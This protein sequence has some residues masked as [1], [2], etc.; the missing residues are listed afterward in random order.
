MRLSAPREGRHRCCCGQDGQARELQLGTCIRSCSCGMS[1]TQ[2]IGCR[3][4]PRWALHVIIQHAP[5]VWHA[6]RV[7]RLLHGILQSAASSNAGSVSVPC[8]KIY[9][10][11]RVRL[12]CSVFVLCRGTCICNVPARLF[13]TSGSIPM[14]GS[15]PDILP[16]QSTNIQANPNPSL[17][18]DMA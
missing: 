5:R 12:T 11:R 2:C 7:L 15:C 8:V 16:T 17:R 4:R 9:S 10:A 3:Q 18:V 13:T 6:W 14:F 1:L